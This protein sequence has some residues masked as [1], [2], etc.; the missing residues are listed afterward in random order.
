MYQMKNFIKLTLLLMV[1]VI[2]LV[3]CAS[4]KKE[5]EKPVPKTEV[6][7]VESKEPSLQTQPTYQD[8]PLYQDEPVDTTTL[9][10]RV[11]AQTEPP[12]DGAYSS[13]NT[14]T[15]LAKA[16]TFY[17]NK[18]YEKALPLFQLAATRQD[19]Q[20]A[21]T[22]AGLYQTQRKLK[23][24]SEA[25]QAFAQLLAISL[26]E[27]NQLNF[28]FL[29]Q[30]DSIEFINDPELRTEYSFWLSEIAKYFQ[31]RKSCFQITG[32]RGQ[33]EKLEHAQDL[34]LLRAKMVQQIMTTH[35]PSITFQSKVVGKEASENIMGTGSN[36]FI[37]TL[38][39]RVEIVVVDCNV[40]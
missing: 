5:P 38:D 2:L 32:H 40:I 10:E 11:L 29:F 31:N 33:K 19:G 4:P 36:D 30:V 13:L 27:N 25:E 26:K 23:H 35:Y 18:D 3:S 24:Q 15:L 7:S 8:S 17:G 34:S 20:L 37:D 12:D 9:E 21:K 14:N 28:R 16:E 6:E 22:Y 1:S 39:R